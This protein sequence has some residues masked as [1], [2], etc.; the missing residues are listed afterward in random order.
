MH[1]VL[2]PQKAQNYRYLRSKC[3]VRTSWHHMFY[4]LSWFQISGWFCIWKMSRHAGLCGPYCRFHWCL[5]GDTP[6]WFIFELK[7]RG[8]PSGYTGRNSCKSQ[9]SRIRCPKK[10]EHKKSA[11]CSITGLSLG[12]RD[13]PAVHLTN[14]LEQSSL[15]FWGLSR[16]LS[17]PCRHIQGFKCAS[18]FQKLVQEGLVYS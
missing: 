7:L 8:M 6:W 11:Y 10:T 18:F 4:F 1:R 14:P 17:L 2:R 13:L 16:S 3:V 5:M 9:Y 12:K 15:S